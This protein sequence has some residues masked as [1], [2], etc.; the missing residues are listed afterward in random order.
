MPTI[1]EAEQWAG[2][3]LSGGAFGRRIPSWQRL[4]EIDDEPAVHAAAV[5]GSHQALLDLG[6]EVAVSTYR[7]LQAVDPASSYADVATR[8]AEEAPVGVE[9]LPIDD[10]DSCRRRPA[11]DRSA[12]VSIGGTEDI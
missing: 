10:G 9:P 6:D 1:E 7:P 3:A 8:L 12:E 11:T 5:D 4:D 2:K